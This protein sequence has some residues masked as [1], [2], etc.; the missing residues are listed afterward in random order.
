[1][2]P[3]DDLDRGLSSSGSLPP[4]GGTFSLFSSLVSPVPYTGKACLGRRPL[5]ALTFGSGSR[6]LGCMASGTAS[7]AADDVDEDVDDGDDDDDVKVV[8]TDTGDGDST[9]DGDDEDDVGE[10]SDGIKLTV[11]LPTSSASS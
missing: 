1:M 2:R 10:S 6:L 5:L 11:S 3:I 7:E 9:D 4:L 8:D